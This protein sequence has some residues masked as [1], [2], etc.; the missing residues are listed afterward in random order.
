[1]LRTK[2]L[3]YSDGSYTVY[4]PEITIYETKQQKISAAGAIRFFKYLT[5]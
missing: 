1:M 2:E 5:Y 3:D 4:R